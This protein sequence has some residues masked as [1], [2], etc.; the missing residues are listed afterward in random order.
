MRAPPAPGGVTLQMTIGPGFRGL[1][2]V[3]EGGLEPPRPFGALAPQA[4]AS[5]YSATRTRCRDPLTGRVDRGRNCSKGEAVGLHRRSARTPG[6]VPP[7]PGERTGERDQQRD[8]R[9]GPTTPPRRSWTSAATSSASTP[10]TPVTATGRGSARPP[11]TSP[12]CSSEVGIEVTVSESD[13]GRTSLLA[14]WGGVTP[15]P[16]SR[17]CWSTATST[18]CPPTPTT[19]RSHPLSG[20][21]KDGPSG[22]AARST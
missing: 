13:P 16:T 20:E 14:R 11:S 4:S 3:S 5:A 8:Q 1:S 18:W 6:R 15:A 2:N 7:W 10:P 21:I 9:P 22:A 17:R 12:R 19:G